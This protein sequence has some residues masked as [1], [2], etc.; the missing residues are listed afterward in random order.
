[1]L[2]AEERPDL[3]LQ[4][5]GVFRDVWPEYNLHGDLAGQYFGALVPQHGHLQILVH[6]C[7][8]DRLVARGRSIPFA[9]DGALEGLP[10]GIDAV[11]LRAL[12]ATRVPTALCALAAEVTTEYQGRGLSRLVIAAMTVLARRA[13]LAP[14]VAPVRPSWKDRYPLIAIDRYASWRRQD[15]LPFDP[16][17]RVHARLNAT[18]LRSEPQSMRITGSVTE[19]EEWTGME[20][21]DDGR[22]VFPGC[23]APLE[24]TDQRGR[25]WEPNVWMLHHI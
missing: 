6:D 3:W 20:F 11:G 7:I 13:G 14:L 16:W 1:V 5:G 19:W 9:W 21:P 12:E 17:M 15:G 25:Y 10:G 24:V 8:R 18:I 23:L 22:Y 4:A 2:T